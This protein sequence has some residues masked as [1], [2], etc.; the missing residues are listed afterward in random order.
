MDAARDTLRV[1]L[2]GDAWARDYVVGA[3]VQNLG[4]HLVAAAKV[5]SLTENTQNAISDARRVCS[6]LGL[7]WEQVAM[8]IR[9]I[10]GDWGP[11]ADIVR[12]L[13]G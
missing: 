4:S 9:R 3:I 11:T 8:A 2:A 12:R 7:D 6:D 13:I 1:R 10:W 5:P